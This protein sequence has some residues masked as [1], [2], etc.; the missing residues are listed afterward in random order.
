MRAVYTVAHPHP[1]PSSPL[2]FPAPSEGGEDV[3][4]SR[5]FRALPLP[6]TQICACAAQASEPGDSESALGLT[7]CPHLKVSRLWPRPY[8]YGRYSTVT[9]E[10]LTVSEKKRAVVI[11]TQG[12]ELRC[13]STCCHVYS[14]TIVFYC[15]IN[16]N[17]I[18]SM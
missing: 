11:G 12:N 7:P 5:P 16:C 18:V 3:G 6:R 15:V 13:S 8:R 1:A 2:F 17:S 9:V 4:R 10:R 14:T